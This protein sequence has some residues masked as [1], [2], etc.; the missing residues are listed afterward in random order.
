MAEKRKQ[1]ED[2]YQQW[3]ADMVVEGSGQ[4]LSD[5]FDATHGVEKFISQ[6]KMKKYIN[7]EE[8]AAEFDLKVSECVNRIRTLEESGRVCGVFDDRGK[9]IV[10]TE[11]EM[12]KLSEEIQSKG[13][14]SKSDVLVDACSRII[15]LQPSEEDKAAIKAEEQKALSLLQQLEGDENENTVNS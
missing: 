9:Y 15:S 5:D 3:K 2:E 1:E 14:I 12:N 7:L 4:R 11:E 13:R 6:I 10:I 8:L